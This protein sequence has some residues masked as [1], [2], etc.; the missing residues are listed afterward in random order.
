MRFGFVCG[1]LCAFA[2]LVV[3]ACGSTPTGTITLTTGGEADALSRAPAPT[4]LE[5]DSIDQDGGVTKLSTT[6]L[7][8]TNIDLGDQSQ[9][10][11]VDLRVQAKDDSGKVLLT[12][13]SLPI[14]LGALAGT[15][16]PIFIQR[17]GEIARMPSTLGDARESPVP[18]LVIGRY[19][20]WSAGGTGGDSSSQ[21]YDTA[22][23]S[24]F[25]APPS[26]PR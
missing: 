9:E 19:I 5:V 18:A 3:A 1:G 11:I 22:S 17:T 12:G 20:L 21:I 15:S 14:E 25:D 13:T 10:S 16:V 2:A 24:P 4:T 6:K 23:L 26:L 7:P 8:A